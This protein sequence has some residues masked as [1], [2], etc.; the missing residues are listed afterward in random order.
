MLCHPTSNQVEFAI[1]FRPA[2]SSHSYPSKVFHT[3]FL[4]W[5]P[6][7]IDVLP[8]H[9]S[10]HVWI[11]STPLPIVFIEHEGEIEH[12]FQSSSH[13]WNTMGPSPSYSLSHVL[14]T[15]FPISRTSKA[16]F[17]FHIPA[18]HIQSTSQIPLTSGLPYNIQI[19][20]RYNTVPTAESKHPFV[21]SEPF[22]TKKSGSNVIHNI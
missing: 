6:L 13:P 18:P 10:S 11:S 8:H 16:S 2:S 1:F 19:K 9:E 15:S 20:E 3:L 17:A 4:D 21:M 14:M 7:R 22:W 5:S 12:S